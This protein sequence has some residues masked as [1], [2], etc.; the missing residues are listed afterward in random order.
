MQDQE[1]ANT[2]PSV[3]ARRASKSER[4]LAFAVAIRNGSSITDAA[5]AVGITRN[6]GSAWARQI[7]ERHNVEVTPDAIATKAELARTL[8]EVLRSPDTAPPYKVTAA[9]GLSK[10]LGYD[11]P[12]R[13]QVEVRTVPASVSAWL[14]GL[15][16]DA[17]DV[18]PEPAAIDAPPARAAL[19]SPAAPSRQD[20]PAT[21]CAAV[22]VDAD[23]SA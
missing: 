3:I 14:D 16:R 18:T 20:E 21:P 7:R 9:A 6:T 5:R 19:V 12:T 2:R 11:A 10:V 23:E 15:E 8:T 22:G 1:P 13:S 17:I 4:R